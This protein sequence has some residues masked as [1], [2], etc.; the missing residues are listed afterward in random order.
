M[1]Q[2]MLWDP[3][4]GKLINTLASQTEGSVSVAFSPD[5]QLLASGGNKEI[6]LWN[7]QTGKRL[8]RLVGHTDS[9]RSVTFSPDG[10]LLV[11]G[12]SDK[13]I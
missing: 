13:T 3:A 10:N 11:S 5:G 7:P 1:S 12:S 9:V 2:L 8:C 6:E 4:T